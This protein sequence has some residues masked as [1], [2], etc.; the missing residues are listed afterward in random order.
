VVSLYVANTDNDWFDFL[1]GREKLSE[2]NFWQ[3]SGKGFRAIEP[4][5]LFAFRLKSPR[6]MIGG[7]GILSNSSVLPL[8]I[9]W[10]TFREANGV[11]S[12]DALRV[13]IAQY[14]P[15]ESIGPATSIG[16]RVLVEPMFFPREAWIDL[17]S[18][19]SKNIMGG[20]R[21]STDE[22]EGLSLW[23][24]LQDVAQGL[25]AALPSG[26]AAP[27]SRYGKPALITPRLGQ[28]AFRVAVTEAYR[29]QCAV[30]EGK[31]LPALDAAHIRPYS[32][33]GM[34]VKSNGILLRKDIHSVLDA[35]YATVDTDYR[36]I[37]SKKVKEVFNNGEEYRRLHGR[38]LLLPERKSDWPDL[39]FLR[40]HNSERF[41]E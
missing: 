5:E 22:V 17:P 24:Q 37:V 3:P 9:A 40:W 35:G 28:G 19:W 18:S 15:G 31:V 16:C 21:Y 29:R 2:V 27:V 8:Q 13:A 6:N 34:H 1:A 39:E 12:Y 20:K 30:T 14:R 41:L 11:A 32:D 25:S 7:F 26:F 33:G 38:A 36:F 23:N 4:G 10:E